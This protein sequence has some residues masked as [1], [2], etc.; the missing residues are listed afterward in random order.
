[1][2][3]DRYHYLLSVLTGVGGPL[4]NV[5]TR[6]SGTLRERLDEGVAANDNRDSVLRRCP[7]TVFSHCFRVGHRSGGPL[8]PTVAS[9]CR[10]ILVADL[11]VKRGR[12]A[13]P[14]VGDQHVEG[15]R[16]VGGRRIGQ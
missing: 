2:S 10:L 1:M 12:L 9:F 11:N 7:V 15:G 8:A 6:A 16:R 3:D 4:L 14:A 5:I 13:R